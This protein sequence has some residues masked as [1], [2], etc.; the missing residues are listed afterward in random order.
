MDGSSRIARLIGYDGGMD[1]E[2]ADRLRKELL[3][4]AAD[5]RRNNGKSAKQIAE[6]RKR[7][8]QIDAAL[9][10]LKRKRDS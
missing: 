6:V 8:T 7:I 3:A 2:A 9:A 4:A 10:R 5:L 1:R